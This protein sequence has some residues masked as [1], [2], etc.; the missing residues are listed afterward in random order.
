MHCVLKLIGPKYSKLQSR[1]KCPGILW[2][3]WGTFWMLL[4]FGLTVVMSL[5]LYK[6]FTWFVLNILLCSADIILTIYFI[7]V[8]GAYVVYLGKMNLGTNNGMTYN[9]NPNEMNDPNVQPADSPSGQPTN[10]QQPQV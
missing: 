5:F 9:P 4:H 1:S 10:S 7:C 3:V 2:I 6:F 8:M